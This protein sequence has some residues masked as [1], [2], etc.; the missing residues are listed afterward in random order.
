MIRSSDGGITWH[1]AARRPA[2]IGTIAVDPLG[3]GTLY[4]NFNGALLRST[5][6][7]SSWKWLFTRTGAAPGSTRNRSVRPADALRH[8]RRR[9]KQASPTASCNEH[10][11][12]QA[13]AIPQV[14][15]AF[16]RRHRNRHRASRPKHDVRS[17]KVPGRP[18]DNGR[19]SHLATVQHRSP[20]AR[21][22]HARSRPDRHHTLRRHQRRRRRARPS[23]L[24]PRP[25]ETAGERTRAA[26]TASSET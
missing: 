12:R 18:A 1:R 25:F 19:R 26:R 11:W 14:G 15:H 9:L 16:H 13:L 2:S 17:D 5:D 4:G 20:G 8:D 22:Q 21:D 3:S 6:G 7:G 24:G 10:R 23:S